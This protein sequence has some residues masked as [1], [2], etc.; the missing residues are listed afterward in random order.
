MNAAELLDN[1]IQKHLARNSVNAVVAEVLSVDAA[2]GLCEVMPTNSEASLIDVRLQATE[3][4][5]MGVKILPVVGSYVVVDFMSGED[6]FVAMYSQVDKVYVRIEDTTVTIDKGGIEANV[7]GVKISADSSKAQ[8]SANE[9]EVT[10]EPNGISIARLGVSLGPLLDNLITQIA[11]ITV[12][13]AAPGTPVPVNNVAF[14][15]PIQQAINQI[16]K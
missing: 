10:V 6:A 5:S 2:R 15:P 11:A 8:L 14:F 9:S 12:T 4:E 16:L 3:G 7:G 13:C 1:Y